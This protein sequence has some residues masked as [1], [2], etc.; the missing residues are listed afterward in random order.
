MLSI[1]WDMDGIIHYEL[2]EKNLTVTAERHCQHLHH[3]EE[4]IQQKHL[5]R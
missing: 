1:W 4:A 5:G 3:L 2:L